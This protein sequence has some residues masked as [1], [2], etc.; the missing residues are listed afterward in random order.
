MSDLDAFKF[1]VVPAEWPGTFRW[2]VHYEG[3][4]PYLH[5]EVAKES[6]GFFSGRLRVSWKSLASCQILS[7]Y[8]QWS[9]DNA[10]PKILN[11]ASL[12][13]SG[14]TNSSYAIRG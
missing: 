1:P 7:N 3:G 4:Y 9:I 10:A 8:D 6:R 11:K 5:L 13:Y 12:H 14:G 2:T